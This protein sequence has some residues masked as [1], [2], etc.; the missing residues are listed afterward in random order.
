MVTKSI[1]QRQA[2]QMGTVSEST[3]KPEAMSVHLKAENRLPPPGALKP[4][5]QPLP[6]HFIKISV[7]S[8]TFSSHRVQ[9]GIRTFRRSVELRMSIRLWRVGAQRTKSC[10]RKAPM[11]CSVHGEINFD[12]LHIT[13]VQ[14]KRASAFSTSFHSSECKWRAA[15][16]ACAK[17]GPPQGVFS[18]VFSASTGSAIHK[19][20]ARLPVNIYSTKISISKQL[21]LLSGPE[22]AFG[23]L[24]ASLWRALEEHRGARGRLPGRAGLPRGK[25]RCRPTS[26]DEMGRAEKESGGSR[27]E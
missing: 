6:L 10:E 23:T 17:A 19:Q 3:A 16:R 1:N 13:L 7:S 12:A 9:W 27:K 5:F 2:E 4:R 18:V 15:E 22:A 26:M 8:P 25:Q 24:G 14:K 21:C 20:C 11:A